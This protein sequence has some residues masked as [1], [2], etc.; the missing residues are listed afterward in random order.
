MNPECSLGLVWHSGFFD[1]RSVDGGEGA[2]Y[3]GTYRERSLVR[4]LFKK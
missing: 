1:V 4:I 2:G 3:D